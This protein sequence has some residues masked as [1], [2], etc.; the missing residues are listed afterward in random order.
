MKSNTQFAPL[1]AIGVYLR[2]RDFFAPLREQVHLDMQTREH[3]PHDKLLDCLVSILAGCTSI[4]EINTRIRPDIALAQAW[5]REQFADQSSVA[6]VLDAFTP[7]N[8]T[9]LRAANETLYH[10]HGQGI[11]HDFDKALLTADIDLIGLPAS[12]HAQGSEKGYFSGEK[13]VADANW[14][15]L[16]SPSIMRRSCHRFTPVDRPARAVLSLQ[17]GIS[18]PC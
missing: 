7:E 8:V 17:C 11:H 18:R 2:R 4:A 13:T 3:S 15:G 9:Q 6:R 14:H 12:R 10:Q 16:A 1:A 5:G